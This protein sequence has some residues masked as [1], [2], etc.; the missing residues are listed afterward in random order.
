MRRLTLVLGAIVAVIVGGTSLN[1]GFGSIWRTAVGLGI[2]ATLQNGLNLLDVNTVSQYVVKG[3]II[4][5]ALGLDV[6]TRYLS[7]SA[8]RRK[9]FTHDPTTGAT[10]PEGQ[11]Q[12]AT[13]HVGLPAQEAR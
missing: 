11:E 4:V 3:L 8:E 6:W 5:G 12:P 13:P 10:K 1:G 7:E 2:L 9:H